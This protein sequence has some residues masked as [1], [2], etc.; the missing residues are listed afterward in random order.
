MAKEG[1]LPKDGQQEAQCVLWCQVPVHSTSASRSALLPRP[2]VGDSLGGP[3][4][5]SSLL[6]LPG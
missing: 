1:L 4:A 2:Q 5:W 6:P 3:T